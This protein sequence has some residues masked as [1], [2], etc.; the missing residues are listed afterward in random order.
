MSRILRIDASSRS[1]GSFSMEFADYFQKKWLEQHPDDEIVVRNLAKDAI[2]HIDENCITGFYT[3]K[4]QH[5]D[6]LKSA[7]RLS[8]TL[9]DELLSA[10]VLLIST[11]MYNFSVPSA[12]KAWIDQ[13]VRIGHTFNFDADKGLYG[14]VEGKR[15]YVVTASGAVFSNPEMAAY[16]FLDPY[17]KTLLGF[18]GI[19]DVNFISI[20]GTT[21]DEKALEKSKQQAIKEIDDLVCQVPDEARLAQASN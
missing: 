5:T 11:P 20:E 8:D 13:I 14:L 15:A 6:A 12:L 10:D 21:T 7:T 19:G 17:L 9:I 4:E 3:P 2:P 18:L 1:H 16:N